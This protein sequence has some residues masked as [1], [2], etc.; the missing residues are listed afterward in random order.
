M[1]G[2]EIACFVAQAP[3]L[4]ACL[5]PPPP[6]PAGAGAGGRVRQGRRLPRPHP[7]GGQR[8]P[9]ARLRG[10]RLVPRTGRQPRQGAALAAHG[11]HLV[12]RW[13]ARRL[14]AG[15]AGA[16]GAREP[17]GS[18]GA[19]QL[20]GWN[21]CARLLLHTP[22]THGASVAD[23]PRG[24]ACAFTPSPQASTASCWWGPRAARCWRASSRSAPARQ[25]WWA[26]WRRWCRWVKG[27]PICHLV[28][29]HVR[30]RP[31]IREEA[32]SIPDGLLAAAAPCPS[33]SPHVPPTSCSCPA[34]AWRCGSTR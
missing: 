6:L 34:P 32:R 27:P 3:S 13:A 21:G 9:A 7:A 23:M 25:T 16:A 29:C 5:P 20:H 24:P 26:C 28:P 4:G 18:L 19:S 14:V 1:G 15:R 31:A 2:Q 10:T 8:Q 11:G 33:P 30:W 17:P 22:E 12:P